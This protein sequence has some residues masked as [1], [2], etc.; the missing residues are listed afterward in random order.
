MRDYRRSRLPGGIYFFTINPL[1]RRAYLPVRHIEPL[2]EAV[3]CTRAEQPFD[4]DAWV[5]LPEFDALRNFPTT[6][7]ADTYL[8]LDVTVATVSFGGT[9]LRGFRPTRALVDVMAPFLAG[10]GIDAALACREHIL[11]APLPSSLRVFSLQRIR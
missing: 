6:A 11:P 9:P 8:R 3:K 1:E 2:Q 10:A 7:E 4:I 5:V